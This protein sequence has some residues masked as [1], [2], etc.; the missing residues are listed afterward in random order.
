MAVAENGQSGVKAGIVLFFMRILHRVSCKLA[1][2][3]ERAWADIN[4]I[5]T[6]WKES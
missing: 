4:P 6:R 2:M 3:V 1:W 5:C